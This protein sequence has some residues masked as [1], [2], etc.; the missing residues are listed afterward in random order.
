MYL[1]KLSGRSGKLLRGLD[2]KERRAL[3]RAPLIAALALFLTWGG[4][5]RTIPE[6]REPSP[7]I[8]W[9]K[10]PEVPR[11]RFVRAISGPEDLGITYPMFKRL[12]GNLAGKA[13]PSISSPYG[14]AVDSSGRVYVV[15]SFQGVVHLFDAKGNDYYPF[16]V[17]EQGLGSPIGIAVDDKTGRV[18]VSDSKQG[19]VK[20]FAGIGKKALREIGR[21]TLKRPTGIAVHEKRGE[22]LVVDTL[23]GA[24][25][26]YSLKDYRVNRVL[27]APGRDQ[28]K[29]HYPT[30]IWVTADGR[31]LVSD[32]LNFRVQ[33]FSP[34]GRFIKAFGSAGDGPG[35]FSRPRGVA[36]D[37]DGN[38]Y[39]VDAL[40]DNV[41]IFNRDGGLLMAFG[42]PGTGY[43]EFCLPT[44]IFIKND[45]I[46]VSD[47]YNKRVQ[48]FQ[49][50]K[51][52]GQNR[53]QIDD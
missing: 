10:V 5:H 8:V 45:T 1:L 43:G 41:Q 28:G 39:V 51:E 48:V 42:G 52:G 3:T 34:E 17:V 9:P 49:Y 2:R 23:A 47:S 21:G 6:T 30:N 36:A 18:Y 31:I 44:G 11:I 4:C 14:V 19:L 13:R 22:L 40:F 46:Y 53:K 27:G 7:P 26:G 25:V 15:D 29:F 37:S 32:S 38:I 35:Y 50:L 12:L 16:A 33:I 20:V 24:V